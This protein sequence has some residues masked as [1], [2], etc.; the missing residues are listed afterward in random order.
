MFQV[1]TFARTVAPLPAV[2]TL[3]RSPVCVC[4]GYRMYLYDGHPPRD[5][6]RN[7]KARVSEHESEEI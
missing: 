4:V 3:P 2:R 5:L 7:N 1:P 6:L